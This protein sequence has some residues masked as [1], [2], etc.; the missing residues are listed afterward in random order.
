MSS[1]LTILITGANRGIGFGLVTLYLCRPSTT[2]IATVRDPTSP[3]SKALQSLPRA[4]ASRLIVINL[5]LAS[6][7]S[8][9]AGIQSL[10]AEHN[11][12]ALD[13]V[14]ANAGLAGTTPPLISSTTADLQ[15]YIN[16]NAFGSLKLYKWVLPLLLKSK[17]QPKFI[18]M[19]SAGGSLTSMSTMVPLAAYGASKAL[20]NFLFKW[21][22][23]EQEGDEKVVVWC[24]HPGM[25][26][27]DMGKAG[28]E[29]LAKQGIDLSAHIIS[30]E[31]ST[32]GIKNVIENAN[33]ENTNGKFLGPDGGELPW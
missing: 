29:L 7:E 1:P 15:T 33:L 10:T 4:P 11:I 9:N 30:V 25:V 27:T 3:S 20:G 21:L 12:H 2:V 24:Q 32:N 5:D 19:S 28:F 26:A 6:T 23:L 16:V 18:Y 8:V 17:A 22:A 31:Q 14:I 13:V